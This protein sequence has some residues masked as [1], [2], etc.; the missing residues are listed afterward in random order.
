M[1][2]EGG[3]KSAKLSPKLATGSPRSTKLDP[4][5]TNMFAES[6]KF[7]LTSASTSSNT[8]PTHRHQHK[9]PRIGQMLPETCQIRPIPAK[10]GPS[11]EDGCYPET[12]IRPKFGQGKCGPRIEV[13]KCPSSFG[14]EDVGI[15]IGR[16]T[17]LGRCS[18]CNS[19]AT[20]APLAH[21]VGAAGALLGH[22]S[23]RAYH[24]EPD[25]SES[26]IGAPAN[27]CTHTH[28]PL[29]QNPRRGRDVEVHY[30][31]GLQRARV[32]DA[33]QDHLAEHGVECLRLKSK[34][35]FQMAQRLFQGASRTLDEWAPTV[36]IGPAQRVKMSTRSGL[37]HLW[38]PC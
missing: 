11:G 25:Q 29:P 28:T 19:R 7:G 36:Q 18:L 20:R 9:K 4:K 23:D 22:R 16:R 37:G 5:S 1:S 15:F 10:V 34:Q 13:L 12:L 21:V 24:K 30:V 17:S 26:K 3:P 31:A 35:Q 33:V 6:A 38:N 32:G 8:C 27:M 2:T 14:A